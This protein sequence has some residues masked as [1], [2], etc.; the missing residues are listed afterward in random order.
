[1]ARGNLVNAQKDMASAI[2]ELEKAEV[3]QKTKSAGT[4]KAAKGP[5]AKSM[6]PR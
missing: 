6:S 2:A 3:D 1:M 5:G 4:P